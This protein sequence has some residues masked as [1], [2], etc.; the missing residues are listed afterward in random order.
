M[1]NINFYIVFIAALIPLAVG[2][3]WY[4]PKVFGNTW[5]KASDMTPEKGK[6]ANMPL[7]FGLTYVFSVLIAMILLSITIHQ[8]HLYSIFASDPSI[9][10]PNSEVRMI[11]AGFM[12]KYGTNFRTFKHGAFHGIVAGILFALPIMGI[13]A[14]FERRGFKYIAINTGYWIV[15]LALMGGVVCQFA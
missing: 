6:G 10:D 3:I 5:M 13:N 1:A 7:V 4:N 8:L 14:L 15:S 12:E 2:F 11:I 9:D